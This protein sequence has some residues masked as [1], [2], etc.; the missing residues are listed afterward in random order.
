VKVRPRSPAGSHPVRGSL[1]HKPIVTGRSLAVISGADLARAPV[2]GA[3]LVPVLAAL[4]ADVG[5]GQARLPCSAGRREA[6]RQASLPV[7]AVPVRSC[8]C[9]RHDERC[10]TDMTQEDLLCDAC[11]TGTCAKRWLGV[12]HVGWQYQTHVA[13]DGPRPDD[14]DPAGAWRRMDERAAAMQRLE[15]AYPG[16]SSWINA[17]D[18]NDWE[19]APLHLVDAAGQHYLNPD[20]P[21]IPH[22]HDGVPC[23]YVP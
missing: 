8:Q 10:A 2:L 6:R 21:L 14:N 4:T 7:M 12:R 22:D 19:S 15:R 5:A 13:W 20:A 23:K 16:E 9:A 18:R 11:R 17:G 1:R 3:A